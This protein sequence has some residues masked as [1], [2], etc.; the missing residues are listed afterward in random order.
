MSIDELNDAVLVGIIKALNIMKDVREEGDDLNDI[1][2][3][4]IIEERRR[5]MV[6]TSMLECVFDGS[7]DGL[8]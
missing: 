1:D 3:D 6:D 8:K 4:Q 2:F 5:D 7:K